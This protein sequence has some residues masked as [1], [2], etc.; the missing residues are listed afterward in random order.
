[1]ACSTA[2]LMAQKGAVQELRLLLLL[3]LPMLFLLLLIV[4]PALHV[5]LPRLLMLLLLL[6]SAHSVSSKLSSSSAA[7]L[8]GSTKLASPVTSCSVTVQ[9]DLSTAATSHSCTHWVALQDRVLQAAL[10]FSARLLRRG[11]QRHFFIT[12]MP[13]LLESCCVKVSISSYCS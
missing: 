12:G 10:S 7:S 5:A 1:M 9:R 2:S 4:P 8:L 11:L 13:L 3:L 6:L